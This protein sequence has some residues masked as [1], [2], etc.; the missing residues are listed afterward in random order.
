MNLSLWINPK[1]AKKEKLE[2][3]QSLCR[4][5]IS[6]QLSGKA[7]DTIQGRFEALFPKKIVT[8]EK[9]LEHKD[10]TLRD[11][12]MSWAKASYIKNIA[13]AILS[14]DFRWNDFHK[15]SDEDVV[16]ELTKIKGVGRWT[17][18]MFLMFTLGR[19]DVFSHGDIGLRRGIENLYNLENPSK[20]KI[21]C[22]VSV[23][24]PY[25][26]YGSIALWQSLEK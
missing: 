19:E 2:Y 7:A 12:G 17:A 21:E 13:T 14:D 8:P 11:A 1:I 22:I 10:Q 4:Q 24:K 25:R 23:W 26:T 18:E 20:K 6:Q 9:L 15:L 16:A 3:F 5:I